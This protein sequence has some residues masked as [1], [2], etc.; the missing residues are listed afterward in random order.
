VASRVEHDGAREQVLEARPEQPQVIGPQ[1]V[2]IVVAD[3]AVAE[4]VTV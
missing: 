3:I 1:V 4:D 2:L